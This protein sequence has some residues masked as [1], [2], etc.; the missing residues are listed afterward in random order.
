MM[1]KIVPNTDTKG[2][3][4]KTAAVGVGWLRNREVVTKMMIGF[5]FLVDRSD[6]VGDEQVWK[7]QEKSR[8]S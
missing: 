1:L 3:N 8:C 5:I 2:T 4:G 7:Q 6:L